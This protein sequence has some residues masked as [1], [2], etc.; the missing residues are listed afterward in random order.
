[1]AFRLSAK[2]FFN[3]YP[4]CTL[5]KDQ[6]RD[7]YK[8]FGQYEHII[9][10]HELHQDGSDHIHVYVKF[11]QKKNVKSSSYF[12]IAG[13][14]GNYQTARNSEAVE[15]YVKKDSDCLEERHNATRELVLDQA[16]NL[17]QTDFFEYCV[18]ERI[19][20]GY[21]SEALR[22]IQR[23]NTIEPDT[24]IDGDE[25]THQEPSNPFTFN[26]SF[27]SGFLTPS[28]HTSLSGRQDAERLRGRSNTSQNQ[29][30][31]S[32]TSTRFE[33]SRRV[34]TNPSSSTIWTSNIGPEPVRYTSLT[35]M[36]PDQSTADMVVP[37]FQPAFRRSSPVMNSH[38]SQT[39]QL[40][41]E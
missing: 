21:Y 37:T 31:S 5:T 35:E 9:V 7:A 28:Y 23:I 13:F 41:G 11:V 30:F 25:V 39:M 40:S 22:L 29:P 14:H 32:P 6:V 3:T 4:Q 8:L 1:M 15:N 16:R 20:P 26:H 38:S 33:P 12:D 24:P 27:P 10:A 18:Q 19:P 2:Q 17:S 36:T 34:Y